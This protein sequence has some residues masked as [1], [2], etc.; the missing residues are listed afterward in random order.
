MQRLGGDGATVAHV[1]DPDVVVHNEYHYG[2]RAGFIMLLIWRR[3]RN[4]QEI[5]LRL[6]TALPYGRGDVRGELRL[7]DHI[8]V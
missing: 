8:I 1:K 4:L 6:P 3:G 5:L 2:T 7:Q